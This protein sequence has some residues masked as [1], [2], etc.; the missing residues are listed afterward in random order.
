MAKPLTGD[1]AD[2]CCFRNRRSCCDLLI[3]VAVVGVES[4][5]GRDVRRSRGGRVGTHLVSEILPRRTAATIP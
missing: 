3:P 2:C 4:Q 5:R 1:R